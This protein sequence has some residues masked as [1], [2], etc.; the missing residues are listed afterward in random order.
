MKK[1]LVIVALITAAFASVSCFNSKHVKYITYTEKIPVTAN[2][3]L[4]EVCERYAPLDDKS[5]NLNE[6]I[7]TVKQLNGGKSSYNVGDVI[8]IQYNKEVK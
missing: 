5:E 8:I 6:Y 1:L 4:W 2:M 3:T 7:Y